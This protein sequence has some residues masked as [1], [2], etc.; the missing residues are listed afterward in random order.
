MHYFVKADLMAPERGPFTEDD[1][2]RLREQKI[3]GDTALVRDGVEKG[4]WRQLG[5]LLGTAAVRR[6][7]MPSIRPPEAPR[8]AANALIMQGLALIV[9]GIGVSLVTYLLAPSNRGVYYILWGLPL[10]GLVRLMR[11]FMS[12]RD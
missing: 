12:G 10:V 6:H 5:A 9:L 1:L 11:G 8:R 7:A 2:R 4:E 3:F